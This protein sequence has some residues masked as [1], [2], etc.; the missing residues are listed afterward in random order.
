MSKW[1]KGSIGE[2]AISKMK[3]MNRKDQKGVSLIAAIFIIVILAFMGIMFVSLIST[4]SFSSV[5]DFKSAQALYIADGGLQYTLALNKNNMP[6]YSTL[7]AWI[8]LSEGQFKVDTISYLTATVTAGDPSISVDSTDSFPAT[9]RI[10][11][12]SEFIEYTAKNDVTDIFTVNPATPVTAPHNQFN[13]V[14]PASSF[15]GFPAAFP[16]NCNLPV[17]PF[18]IPVD[19]DTGGFQIPG[20]IFIDTEYFFCTGTAVVPVR[21]TGCERCFANSASAAH[22]AG[23]FVSQYVL[24]STGRVASFGGDAERVVQVNTGPYEE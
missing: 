11:I 19:D 2:W 7:G 21:F 12:D 4:G 17:S 5:N 20:I 13:S 14:Y 22:P 9:G 10:T 23:R 24:T 8:N 6:N 15:S 18:D 3:Q 16:N 1:V